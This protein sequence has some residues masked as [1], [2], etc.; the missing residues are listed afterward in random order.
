MAIPISEHTSIYDRMT[1]E[2]LASLSKR[3]NQQAFETL[4]SRFAN[5]IRWKAGCYF[6]RGATAE[7]LYQE[8]CLG[9]Y[10]AVVAYQRGRPFKPFAFMCIS[11]QIVQ[12]VKLAGTQKHYPLNTAISLDAPI[13]RG[14]E[15]SCL[16]EILPDERV[17]LPEEHLLTVQT[18]LASTRD[19]RK[20]PLKGRSRHDM[21]LTPF[22]RD[23]LLR[24]IAGY[25][26]QEISKDLQ[27]DTKA[28][29][30]ALQRARHKI[31]TWLQIDVQ[32]RTR[33]RG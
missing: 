8:G 32:R 5:F 28:I 27:R 18:L 2:E 23:V 3:G 12:T 6:A 29:D 24:I 31:A 22:E 11:R 21:R 10:E 20:L 15:Y 4:L 17:Q 33:R 25:S 30:N 9:L 13:K 14:E 16:V 7:D 19:G 26:Y 1:D